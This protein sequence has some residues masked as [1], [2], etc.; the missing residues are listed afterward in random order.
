ML[1][2]DDS[3]LI[4]ID[5]Q[6]K[7]VNMLD[8]ENKE[9]AITNS[10]KIIQASNILNIPVIITEQYPKGLGLTIENVRDCL[11]EKYYP[12]EKTSFSIV[13]DEN[14]Y[15]AIIKESKKQIVLFGIEA[16]ICVFQ[17]A[18]ELKEKGY[19]VYVVSDIT[20]SRNNEE[21]IS[22][23]QNLR[24]LNIQTPSLETVLFMWLETSKNPSFKEIQNLIK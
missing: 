8:S 22:S 19:E 14:I 4:I 9:K 12:Y 5:V 15:N 7:L 16:H 11:N 13:K 17:S 20:F 2:K 6:D 18:L 24:H 1:N 21:K 10:K 3:I 23:L